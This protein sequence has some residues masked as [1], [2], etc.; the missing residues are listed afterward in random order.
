MRI[1][2]GCGNCATARDGR[3]GAARPGG[4]PPH[5]LRGPYHRSRILPT[6]PHEQHPYH[7]GTDPVLASLKKNEDNGAVYKNVSGATTDALTVLSAAGMNHARL[8]VWVNALKAQGTTADM[9]QIGTELNGGM[10]RPAGSTSDWSQLAGLSTSGANAAKAVS[11]S[12]EVSL[13]L[14]NG[15]DNAVSYKVIGLSFY[16]YWHGPLSDLQADMDDLA[17][18]YGKQLYVAE[19]AY[20]FT[21]SGDDGWENQALFDYDGAPTDAQAWF[22][23]R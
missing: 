23:H 11:S 18:R 15:G 8:R 14:A 21:L 2:R 1:S 16:G 5:L 12:T 10:L 22:K 6:D 7:L 4:A 20:P 9:V 13:H 19:T 17:T 3:E